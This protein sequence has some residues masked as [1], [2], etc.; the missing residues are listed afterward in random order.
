MVV[1]IVVILLVVGSLIFHFAS[2]WWFTPIASNWGTIDDTVIL[3]FWVTGIVFIALNL[4][5]AWCVLKFRHRK[6]HKAKYEPE[7]KKLEIWL[8]GLTT[9]GVVAMLAPGLIVWGDVVTVPDDAM[10]VEAVGQQWHW[11][12]RYPGDDQVFGNVDPLLINVDNPFGMDPDDPA[13]LDDVLVYSPEMHLPV[14]QPVKMM[15][16]SKDV[17]HNYAVPQFRVKMDLV[18][19]MVTYIWYEPTREGNF[20]I[21]CEELC[22]MA[23]HTM[24]GEVVVESQE[25]F[26]AWL[27]SYPTFAEVQQRSAP[28][29]NAGQLAYATC[30]A[31][32]GANGEGNPA[33]NAP[34]LAGIDDWYLKRQLQHYKAG[35]RGSDPADILGMQM[36][37]M[38]ATLVN[39]AAIDNVVAYID[40]L[41]DVPAVPTID[42]D[43]ERGK[44]LYDT[45]VNCHGGNGQG[46]WAM[47]APRAAGMSDW[48]VAQ[49]LR[50][51]RDGIR[52]THPDD[53]YGRQMAQMAKMLNEEQEINDLVAYMNTLGQTKLAGADS[54]PDYR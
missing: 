49:Q 8:T 33:L 46:I 42:G 44:A 15:L 3:T 40:T 28:D 6:G 38:A 26:D 54:S 52:G 47:N 45:C 32:H 39:E 1:A 29:A 20:E 21:L 27:D 12:F 53:R 36:R 31:C 30:V 50:N 43:I 16:R 5:M 4:F 18:P 13:G 11:T 25:S 10:E 23:H 48:Y 7:N 41:P 35:I 22:G 51:F 34:K 14:G 9:V 37:G 19:G 17:L 24:R 2:P